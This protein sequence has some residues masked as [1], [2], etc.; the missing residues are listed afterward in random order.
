MVLQVRMMRGPLRWCERIDAP[1][2]AFGQ[3]TAAIIA[4]EH[5]QRYCAQRVLSQAAVCGRR[6]SMPRRSA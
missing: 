1:I 2:K 4:I 3:L 5:H 6:V